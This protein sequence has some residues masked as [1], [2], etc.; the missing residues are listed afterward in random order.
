MAQ[1]TNVR[2]HQGIG[3]A[4]PKV[5]DIKATTRRIFSYM[6]EEKKRFYTVLLLILASSGLSLAGPYLLGRTVDLVI[7]EPDLSV[8]LTMLTT[9]LFIYGFQSA[10]LWLQNYWMIGIAQNAVYKMRNHLFSHLQRLPILFF[11]E[12]QQGELMSR[13]TNDME[14]VSRTLNTA[15]VQFVTSVLT[16][17]GTLVMMLWL[18]PLLTLLTITIVP[19]MYFG[20]KWI[21]KRTEKY[22]KE[23]QHHLGEVNGYVEEMFSGQTI[24]SMFSREEQVIEEFKGKN[25][26]LRDSGY[27]AQVYTG[28]IPKLMNML[29]NV[30]FAIIVGGGGLLALNGSISIGVIVTFTTYSR[31]FTRPLND[32]AN[33]FNMILSAVAGAERVFDIIDKKVEEKDE[34]KAEDVPALEGDVRFEQVDFSYDDDQ[35]TLKDISFHAKQGETVALVG[36]T[37]AGKTTIISLLSRFYEPSDGII[38][39]DGKPL[40]EM[41]RRSLRQQMGV[42]LQDST[43]FHTTIRENIRYGRLDATDEEVEQAARAAH[44][45]EFIRQLPDGYDTWLDSDGHGVSHG[46]RQLL[47]IARA[48][49]ANPSLLIL[50]E[51]TSSIDTV[52][53]MKIN[54]ALAKLMKG[55]TSFVI[56]HRLNTIRSADL[57]LVLQDGQI[58]EKG[59]HRELLKQK[60]FYADLVRTQMAEGQALS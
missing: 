22:F 16:I 33:Q 23:Q 29:N 11:Q 20:M 54:D 43:M 53:E 36:P 50:D 49:I 45:D 12:Y 24:V 18:S 47:S 13:L 39:M 32:L 28:F 4:P 10:F 19:V 44:A 1:R 25:E 26:A 3:T 35:S 48:M 17:T 55:R 52:T 37:G 34:T 6:K 42:V 38:L 15:I 9:L 59:S 57:I 14:N 31:Q 58:I 7:A 30:S 56:A 27:W 41:T 21:T 51:A 40:N 5:N 46:Q 60:G 8:L 2:R